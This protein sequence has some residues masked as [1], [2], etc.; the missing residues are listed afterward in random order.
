MNSSRG[1]LR[2]VMWKMKIRLREL[3]LRNR[4]LISF[5]IV[6]LHYRCIR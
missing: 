6:L 4:I 1:E 2:E 3:E 5:F